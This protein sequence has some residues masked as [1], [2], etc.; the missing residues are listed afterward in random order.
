MA[1]TRLAGTHSGQGAV[2]RFFARGDTVAPLWATLKGCAVAIVL[3]IVLGQ[4]FGASGIA[5]ALALGAWSN[6]FT[7]IR[8]GAATF[9]F[10]IDAAA[11]RRLPR[12]GIA[13]LAMGGLLWLKATYVLPLVAGASGIAQAAVLGVLIA[14]G[15]AI[16]GLLLTLFGVI[17]WTAALAAVRQ[18]PSRDLPR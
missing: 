2:T 6:A 4:I 15:L 13:A 9:G 7:L 12:I 16:Y 8:R 5:A 1:G 17:N 18:S 10:S 3:A 14:G 11:R